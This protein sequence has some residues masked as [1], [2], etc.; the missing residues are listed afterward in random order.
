MSKIEFILED[1]FKRYSDTI[2][3]VFY[4]CIDDVCFPCKGW[5]DFIYPVL[6]DWTKEVLKY[7]NA[8]NVKFSLYFMD[9][10]YHLLCNKTNSDVIVSLFYNETMKQ[11]VT[12]KYIDL[13]KGL[14]NAIGKFF[15]YSKSLQID[16]EIYTKFRILLQQ[17]KKTMKL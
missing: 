6:Y 4:I 9:G 7:N 11:Y 10:P 5:T 15:R 1:D 12:I 16:G 17:I 2:D 3:G 8:D 14:K 13:I